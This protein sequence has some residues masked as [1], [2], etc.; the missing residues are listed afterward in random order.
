MEKKHI[1]FLLKLINDRLT[2][3]FNQLLKEKNITAKQLQVLEYLKANQEKPITQKNL[4]VAFHVSHP[5]ISRMLKEME[6]NAFINTYLS[7]ENKKMKII[8]FDK[9]KLEEADEH[10]NSVEKILTK[11]FT[12]KEKEQLFNYLERVYKNIDYLNTL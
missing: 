10:R 8:E 3:K 9:S 2:N 5:T 1:G 12:T 11:D 6:K 7:P 4:E